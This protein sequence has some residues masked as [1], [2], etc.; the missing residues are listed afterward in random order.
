MTRLVAASTAAMYWFASAALTSLLPSAKPSTL[1]AV[2]TVGS[3]SGGVWNGSQP[4]AATTGA[5]TGAA[6]P[7]ARART[8]DIAG[9]R[10]RRGTARSFVAV[11]G[12]LPGRR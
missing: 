8:T 11:D 2:G 5:A 9:T 3:M 1:W 10:N 7:M 6:G 4:G 12:Q